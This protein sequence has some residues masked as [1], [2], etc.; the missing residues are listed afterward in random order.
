MGGLSRVT[1]EPPPVREHAGLPVAWEGWAEAPQALCPRA[2]TWCD[3]CGYDGARLVAHGLVPYRESSSERALARIEARASRRPVPP[4]GVARSWPVHRLIA[5]RCPSC[6][7]LRVYDTGADGMG[8][9]DVDV[10]QPTLF[11]SP[12]GDR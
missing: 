11:D 2:R 1:S 8:W 12:D 5:Y 10:V 9:E 6:G 4:S 3:A 7:D